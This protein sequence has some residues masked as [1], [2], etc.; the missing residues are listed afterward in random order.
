LVAA[1]V[2][3]ARPAPK[4]ASSQNVAP[5]VDVEY[6]N[7]TGVTF[8]NPNYGLIVNS[9][10]ENGV[11]ITNP[12]GLANSDPKAQINFGFFAPS[13]SALQAPVVR[14]EKTDVE[15]RI[16][17]LRHDVGALTKGIDSIRSHLDKLGA[18]LKA[19]SESRSKK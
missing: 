12:N 10:P 5:T 2:L 7:A 13:Q 15:K 1:A 14:V 8:T 3:A 9:T 4:P 17:E 11:T 18:D 16:D 6:T 19:L